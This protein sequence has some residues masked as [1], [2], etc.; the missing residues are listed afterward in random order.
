MDHPRIGIFTI[1][2]RMPGAP[3]AT[4]RLVFSGSHVTGSGEVTQAT[5]PP[6]RIETYVVGTFT[7]IV[8]GADA[9]LIIALTG[10]KYPTVMPPDP[11][12][13]TCTIA[14]DTENVG[15]GPVKSV[16]SL[17]YLD[18]NGSWKELRDQPAAVTWLPLPEQ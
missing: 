6:L 5:N 16:A 11:V 9:Q 13:A 18:P 17:A 14:L 2:K 7:E 12:N 8:W 15:K 10:H 4:F 3:I 1:G